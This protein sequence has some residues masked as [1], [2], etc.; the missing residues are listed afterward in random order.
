[1]GNRHFGAHGVVVGLFEVISIF[2]YFYF[3]HIKSH[4]WILC[5]LLVINCQKKP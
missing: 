4:V 1:M 3:L 2:I 5:G